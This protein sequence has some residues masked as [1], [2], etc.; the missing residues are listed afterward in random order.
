M[1]RTSWNSSSIGAR[2]RTEGGAPIGNGA[3]SRICSVTQQRSDPYPRASSM[4]VLD[5]FPNQTLVA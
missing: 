3:G 5:G 2:R 1:P 4:R